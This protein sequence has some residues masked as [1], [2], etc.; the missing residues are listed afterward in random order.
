MR[1]SYTGNNLTDY[2]TIIFNSVTYLLLDLHFSFYSLPSNDPQVSWA[3]G[4]QP[5]KSDRYSIE[6]MG[7]LQL[8]YEHD[9]TTIRVRYNILRGVMCF[10]AIINMS[11]L[12]R[13][14]RMLQHVVAN[15]RSR[16]GASIYTM[17]SSLRILCI[18]VFGAFVRNRSL[19]RNSHIMN[20]KSW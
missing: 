1:D 4:L 3:P 18:H 12:S 19:L 9:S 14:C 17:T 10:R 16:G 13:C 5:A 7:L 15:Q 6:L 11:I 2:Y 8:R 20:T